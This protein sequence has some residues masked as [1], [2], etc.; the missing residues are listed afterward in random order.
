MCPCPYTGLIQRPHVSFLF[1]YP[2]A[3]FRNVIVGSTFAKPCRSFDVHRPSAVFQIA[4]QLGP[5]SNETSTRCVCRSG[6]EAS[7]SGEVTAETLGDRR[8]T[9]L[10]RG[11]G[12]FPQQGMLRSGSSRYCKDQNL[13]KCPH[14]NFSPLLRDKLHVFRVRLG[15]APK[16]TCFVSQRSLL[17]LVGLMFRRHTLLLQE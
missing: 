1:Q 12:G 7:P 6:L 5:R 8:L 15:R 3:A 17:F 11:G 9:S 14:P 4:V 13:P 2:W 16:S 10:A